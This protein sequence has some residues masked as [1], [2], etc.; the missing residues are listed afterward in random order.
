M[1]RV[2]AVIPARYGSTRFPGKPLADVGGR[3]MIEAVWRATAGARRVDRVVVAT[4]DTRIA[5]VAAAFGADVAMTSRDHPSGTDR[6]AEAVAELGPEWRVVLHVQGDEPLV[7]PTALDR[8]VEAF[9]GAAAPDL[10]TLAEP[11]PTID[12]LF[13][14]QVVKVV[15]AQDGRALYFSRSPIPYHRGTGALAAD[16]RAALAVRPAGLCGY[17]KHQGIYAWRRDALIRATGLPPSPL[18][19]DEGL[20]QLRVLEAGMTIRVLESDFRSRAVDTPADLE[21]VRRML[22]EVEG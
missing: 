18:E 14:P 11:V 13:D 17:Y 16:F 6:V 5:D 10:A 21:P 1:S 22:L 19:V 2:V 12:E 9:D 8:L 7:T 3:T 15:L 20:E 4:D